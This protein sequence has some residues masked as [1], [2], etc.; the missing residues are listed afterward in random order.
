[1][2]VSIMST[3]MH[4][5]AGSKMHVISNPD[6]WQNNDDRF[7]ICGVGY[8]SYIAIWCSREF[9]LLKCQVSEKMGMDPGSSMPGSKIQDPRYFGI[10]TTLPLF[11]LPKKLTIEE[12]SMK[13]WF[14][15]LKWH[16]SY[17]SLTQFAFKGRIRGIPRNMSA[18][19]FRR[20]CGSAKNGN[21]EDF[22]CLKA[23][24]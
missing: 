16:K 18:D 11:I 8:C 7:I 20:S 5:C 17:F 10:C 1:M 21:L 12:S 3:D 24:K 15:L 13:L 4:T 23:A 14:S 6:S 22:R 9:V 2:N 19:M